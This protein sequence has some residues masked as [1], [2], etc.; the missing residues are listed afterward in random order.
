MGTCQCKRCNDGQLRSS[1]ARAT[2]NYIGGTGTFSHGESYT[3]TGSGFG[4]RADN[5][6]DEDYLC[7]LWDDFDDG[8]FSKWGFPFGGAS[9]SISTTNLRPNATYNAHKD[10][11]NG[12]DRAQAGISGSGDYL[13]MSTHMF[14]A[15]NANLDNNNKYL[16]SGSC[17]SNDANIIVNSNYDSDNFICTVEFAKGL[18][19]AYGTGSLADFVGQWGFIEVVWSLQGG[20]DYAEVYCNGVL[21]NVHPVPPATELW[22]DGDQFT[23]SPYMSIGTWFSGDYGIGDGIWYDGTYFDFTHSRVMAGNASTFSA[24]TNFELQPPIS[25]SDTSI[26]IIVNTGPYNNGENLWL[27][28][29]DANNNPVHTDG[30]AV[31]VG[32]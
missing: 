31:T 14:I 20:A 19:P 25:W 30:I 5:G 16:R 27:Y 4:T 7:R 17:P 2:E 9:W 28:V 11:S 12:L 1:D 21:T 8:N 22:P 15:S 29:V 10:D 23:D 26:I 13:Y 6:G 3:I 24:C 18:Q 32:S